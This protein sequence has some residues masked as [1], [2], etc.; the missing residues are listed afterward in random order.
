MMCMA[1]MYVIIKSEFTLEDCLS[2]IFYRL[3]E[4]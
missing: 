2:K 1:I 3:I 4:T